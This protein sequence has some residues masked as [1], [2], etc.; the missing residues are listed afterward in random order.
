MSV[1]AADFN[2]DGIPDLAVAHFGDGNGNGAGVSIL[3]G[4]GDG[5]PDLAFPGSA[6]TV[7]LNAAD[8]PP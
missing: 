3:L 5:F 1:V 4:N 6:T 8:W 7:L 2:G